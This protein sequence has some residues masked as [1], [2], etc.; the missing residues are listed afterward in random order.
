MLAYFLKRSWTNF[1][2]PVTSAGPEWN[3]AYCGV[4][5]WNLGMKFTLRCSVIHFE[6]FGIDLVYHHFV[7][8]TL[9]VILQGPAAREPFLPC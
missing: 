5:E 7:Y 2:K 3:V 4:R 1:R 6:L 8:V 9:G